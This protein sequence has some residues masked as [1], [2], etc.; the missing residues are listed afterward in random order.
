M[1]RTIDITVALIGLALFSP[2]F[3]IV[4][5]VVAVCMGR[6]VLFSQSRPGRNLVPFTLRKFRTM[7]PED[8]ALGPQSDATRLSRLGRT[9]RRS[10]L[11]ELPQLVNILKGDMSLVG[12]RPLLQRYLPYFTEEER[13][14]FD[15]RPGLT[16]WAQV[17]GRNLVK[18]SERLAMDSWYVEH[19]SVAL[20]LR[21]LAMTAR[22]VLAGRGVVQ[23]AN[24]VMA[25]LDVE[26]AHPVI[27]L[28]DRP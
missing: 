13:R 10:S 23:D 19:M 24:V 2:I 15:V 12:P 26:R 22:Q 7:R 16:G 3:C 28:E 18:W 8:P 6:P 5:M 21:I 1:K 27:K 25:D 4:A 20:D 11:D 14:R 9:L 17:H